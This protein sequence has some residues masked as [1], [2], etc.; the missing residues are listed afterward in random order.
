MVVVA[1]GCEYIRERRSVSNPVIHLPQKMG[2]RVA[3][4]SFFFGGSN[5]SE[6]IVLDLKSV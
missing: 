3:L 1:M 2:S 6:H 4:I 5:F